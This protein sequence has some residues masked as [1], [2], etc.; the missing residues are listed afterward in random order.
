LL[1]KSLKSDA[2]WCRCMAMARGPGLQVFTVCKC[3]VPVWQCPHHTQTRCHS[4]TLCARPQGLVS[5]TVYK[6]WTMGILSAQFISIPNQWFSIKFGIVVHTNSCHIEFWPILLQYITYF[7]K[8]W[9]EIIISMTRLI[10]PNKVQNIL[11]PRTIAQKLFKIM[12]FAL[13]LFSAATFSSMAM[14]KF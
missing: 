9:S 2:C 5:V 13:S 8:T 1:C 11:R 4:W 6:S 7:C 14:I 10:T 3:Q 12:Y